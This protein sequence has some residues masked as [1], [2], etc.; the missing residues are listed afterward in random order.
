M[1]ENRHKSELELALEKMLSGE[2]PQ[3]L[4]VSLCYS[5]IDDEGAKA[6]ADAIQSEKCPQRLSI[7]LYCNN[8]GDEGVKAITDAL[9]SKNCPA[10]LN[11]RLGCNNIGDKGL[12]MI[13]DA[14]LSRKCP[15]GLNINL[16]SSYFG[17]ALEKEIDYLV[18]RNKDYHELNALNRF[19]SIRAF[20]MS[21]QQFFP[22]EIKLFIGSLCLQNY[23]LT[24]NEKFIRMDPIKLQEMEIVA[25]HLIELS[26]KSLGYNP[27]FFE[28]Q[29][30]WTHSSETM[31][32][33]T[34]EP[35]NGS[36][37]GFDS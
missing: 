35:K 11:M 1:V 27:G 15:A 13:A 20:F 22:K 32:Q 4:D 16:Y 3:G 14:L 31:Q 2:H 21:T 19:A 18:Q 6:I 17:G 8:I 26:D 25:S 30:S 23:D 28:T 36:K 34:V 12:K 10:E 29:K 5:D 9:Q 24:L 33:L 37:F 7:D